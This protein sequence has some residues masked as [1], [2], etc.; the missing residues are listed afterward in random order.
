MGDSERA[1][2]I[3]NSS[4][5][6]SERNSFAGLPVSRRP[7]ATW[8]PGGAVGLSVGGESW[9]RRIAEVS[10]PPGTTDLI[11]AG[12]LDSSRVRRNRARRSINIPEAAVDGA[13]GSGR[14]PYHYRSQTNVTEGT[15]LVGRVDA[16]PVEEV[17]YRRYQYYTRL[18]NQTGVDLDLLNIPDHVVP[19][20]FYTL[21]FLGLVKPEGKQSSIITIFSLWNTMLG[22][23]LLSMP[24]ALE[25]A[26]I[27]MGIAMMILLSGISLYTAYRILQVYTIHS[28]TNKISEFSDL[29]GLVLGKWAELIA[30]IFSVLAILGAAIVYW[31]LMSNFLYNTV[32]YMYDSFTGAEMNDTGVYCPNNFSKPSDYFVIEDYN[33]SNLR[34]TDVINE[35]GVSFDKVW[36]QFTTVPLFLILVLFPL[37]NLKSATFFTKFN[38]L[39]TISI[40]FIAISVLYRCYEWGLHAEFKDD[41]SE[42]YVALYRDSFPSLTGILALGLFI[43]NAI[44]TIMS[45]NKNPENNGRDMSIG[46]ILVIGTYMMIGSAF[47]LAFPL[48]K[49]CIEDNLLNNFMKHDGLNVAAKVFLFLQMTTVFPLIMYILRISVLFPI[50]RELWPGAKYVILLNSVIIIICVSFAIFMPK[51]GTIIRY[52]GAACGMSMIFTL[53]VL[54]HLVQESKAGSLSRVSLILHICIIILG[55]ANFIAQF[56]I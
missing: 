9:T 5:T 51:I 54:V 43:H 11:A 52:S 56:F 3:R 10:S 18:Q 31:V 1:H 55:A 41:T 4:S 2:L 35:W 13:T 46:F 32:E 49:G 34:Q 23:S 45:N 16:D 28:R 14:R 37:V 12:S 53:P 24:W 19:S 42:E 27:L 26:G 47:Y 22:T 29:C 7:G 20:N 50:F 36:G 33:T 15:P 48:P 39:G 38:S 8:A 6:R 30:T 40:L 21:T 17:H 25:Q 44:I